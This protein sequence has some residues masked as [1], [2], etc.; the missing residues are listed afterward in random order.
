MGANVA[1]DDEYEDYVVKAEEAQS[2]AT[3]AK[4]AASKSS[5]LRIAAGYRELAALAEHR[6]R[7]RSGQTE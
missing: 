5:W 4:D 6:R 7:E 1:D 2:K 3:R